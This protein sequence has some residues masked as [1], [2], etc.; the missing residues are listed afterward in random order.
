[1]CTAARFNITN[2]WSQPRCPITNECIRKMLHRYTKEEYSTTKKNKI[3]SLAGKWMELE[4]VR[5]CQISHPQ[6]DMLHVFSHMWNR[7]IMAI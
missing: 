3:M 1:M 6:K 5:V 7:D 2:L 4:I